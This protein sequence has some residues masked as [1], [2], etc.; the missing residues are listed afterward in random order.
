MSDVVSCSLAQPPKEAFALAVKVFLWYLKTQ[1]WELSGFEVTWGSR[2]M[3][4]DG[5]GEGRICN[6]LVLGWVKLC[7]S[8]V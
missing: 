1:I 7:V 5:T 3:I 4:V 6:T 8:S 2:W